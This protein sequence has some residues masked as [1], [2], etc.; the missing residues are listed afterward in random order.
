MSKQV[1]ISKRKQTPAD[2]LVLRALRQ[3]A[4]ETLE[5]AVPDRLLGV[6]REARR[7]RAADGEPAPAPTAP[8][9]PPDETG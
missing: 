4:D 5:E 7:R 3:V 1:K 6:I 2:D 9:P 8:A